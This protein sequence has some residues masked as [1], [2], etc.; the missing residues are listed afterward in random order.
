MNALAELP[1]VCPNCRKPMWRDKRMLEMLVPG[2]ADGTWSVCR[3]CSGIF[4]LH[5][6]ARL[7]WERPSPQELRKAWPILGPVAMKFAA[8][9]ALEAHDP[10]WLDRAEARE[11][12][13][14]KR[15]DH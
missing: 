14:D 2:D 12:L 1:S 3:H 15:H 7:S 11:A 9:A 5:R 13:R 8:I 10:G 4:V 6:A